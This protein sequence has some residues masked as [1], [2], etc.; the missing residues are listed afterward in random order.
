MASRQPAHTRAAVAAGAR[1]P[2][3]ANGPR[4]L[5][6]TRGRRAIPGIRSSLHAAVLAARVFTPVKRFEE[7]TAVSNSKRMSFTHL[8]LS[9]SAASAQ[10]FWLR[11]SQR[12]CLAVL[13]A[14]LGLGAGTT[15]QVTQLHQ[16]RPDCGAVIA[17]CE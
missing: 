9:R 1:A 12:A 15:A 5:A 6:A 2:P 3:K 13:V 4:S 10:P 16:A 7:E 14:L 8:P 11:M 17:G